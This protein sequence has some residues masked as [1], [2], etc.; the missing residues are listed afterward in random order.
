MGV[1]VIQQLRGS[2][3]YSSDGGLWYTA[4]MGVCVIQLKSTNSLF[5]PYTPKK[6]T[7]NTHYRNK[8]ILTSL[9]TVRTEPVIKFVTL[10]DKRNYQ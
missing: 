2:V 1:S 5:Q 9:P 8:L 3:V 10:H 4:V 7:Q 6:E